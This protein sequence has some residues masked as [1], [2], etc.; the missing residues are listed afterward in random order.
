MSES[1]N[2]DLIII[3]GGPAG[4]AAALFAEKHHLKTL[5]VEKDIFPRDKICGDA[6]SG[7]SM[8]VLKELD[9]LEEAKQLP[10]AVV[11]TIIF[12]SPAHHFINIDLKSNLEKGIQ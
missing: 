7:K 4:S 10:G 9:L 6:I 11:D 12:G 5:I 3:G 2:F 1:Y 8:S